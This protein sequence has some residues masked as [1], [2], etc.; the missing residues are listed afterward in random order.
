MAKY[1]V[2]EKTFINNRLYEPGAVVSLDIDK[3]DP[4][5]HPALRPAEDGEDEKPKRGRAAKADG[6]GGDGDLA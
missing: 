4:K 3:F 6:E 2:I 5:L 1:E